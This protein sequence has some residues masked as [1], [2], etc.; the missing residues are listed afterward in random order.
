VRAIA[1]G[2]P[3]YNEVMHFLIEEAFRLDEGLFPEWLQ[4][5]DEN[6]L[7]TMAVRQSKRRKSGSGV[8]DSM[9][10]FREDFET[11]SFKVQRMLETDSAFAEDPPSRVRRMVTNLRL[12]ETNVPGEYLAQSYLLL[13]RS[14]GDAHQFETF[15]GRRDDVLRVGASG[16]QLVR[17]NV[18]VDQAVLG[19]ANLAIFI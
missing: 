18:I 2:E 19:L 13:H 11:L 7:C 3:I 8:S 16:W 6:V 9:L 4:M 10:W 17:R 14:R 5:L 12:S 15:S 1:Y